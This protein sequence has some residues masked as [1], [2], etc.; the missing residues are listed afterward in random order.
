MSAHT[1]GTTK[2]LLGHVTVT[3]NA[4]NRIPADEILRAVARHERGDWGELGRE[5][6][7]ANESALKEGGRLVS[8]YVSTNQVKFLIITEW[9]RKLTTVLLPEDY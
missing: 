3:R 5:D 1:N 8:R 9:N 6:I 4:L 2:F 7:E